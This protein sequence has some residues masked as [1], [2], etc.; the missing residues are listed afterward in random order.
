[1]YTFQKVT[2][3]EYMLNDTYND[4]KAH[5]INNKWVMCEMSG[6]RTDNTE[7]N[8]LLELIDYYDTLTADKYDDKEIVDSIRLLVEKAKDKTINIPTGCE[9][10]GF[11]AGNYTISQ[12]LH[13]IADMAE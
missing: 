8:T 7:H 12:L 4:Y 1:M 13:F 11:V 6:E 3:S 2:D 10:L 5:K 9:N